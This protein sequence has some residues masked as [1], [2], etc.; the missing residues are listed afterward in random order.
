MQPS[1][2]LYPLVPVDFQ[3]LAHHK[4]G[5][6]ESLRFSGAYSIVN[7]GY[8]DWSCTVPPYRNTNSIDKIHCSKWLK[9]MQKDIDCTFGILKGRWSILKSGVRIHGVDS[10]NNFWFTCCAFHNWLLNVVRFVKEWVGSIHNISSNWD[11][12]MGCLDFEGV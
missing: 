11:G 1:N 3:L 2:S 4:E 5:Q 12:E 7:D 10:V 6:V 8:L 9:S